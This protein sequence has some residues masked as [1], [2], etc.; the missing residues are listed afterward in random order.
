MS[1][2]A[3]SKV[4]TYWQAWSDS[5]ALLLSQLAPGEWQV[6]AEANANVDAVSDGYTA[7]ARVRITVE[8]GLAGGSPSPLPQPTLACCWGFFWAKRSALAASL[9]RRRRKDSRN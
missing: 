3:A 1:P 2:Q 4:E 8:G 7:I 6:E 5:L 9:T